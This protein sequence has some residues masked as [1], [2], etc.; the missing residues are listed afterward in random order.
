MNY[1]SAISHANLLIGNSSSGIIEAASFGKPVVNIG[2]RQSGRL[3]GVNIID[4]EVQELS[5]SIKLALS[6]S[7]INKC[8][9]IPNVYGSGKASINI[10]NKLITQPLSVKKFFLDIK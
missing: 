6:S 8:R 2:D 3:K 5:N 10:V 9:D 4:C 7:F 1:L